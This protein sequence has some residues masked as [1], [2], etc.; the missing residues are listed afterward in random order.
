[1]HTITI[2]VSGMTCEHCERAVKEELSALEGVRSVDVDLVAGGD[3]SVRIE[4]D[5]ELSDTAIA[6]AVEEAGYEVR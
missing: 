2:T 4:S 5:A 1:M 6:A 3:S